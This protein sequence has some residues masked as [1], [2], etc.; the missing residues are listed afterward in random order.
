MNLKSKRQFLVLCAGLLSLSLLSSCG[1]SKKAATPTEIPE[2]AK[3]GVFVLNEGSF[4]GDNASLSFIDQATDVVHNSIY[5]SENP[6][7][8]LGTG[9]NAFTLYGSK[10]YV[11]VFGS[12]K[13]EILSA[14]NTRS[15]KTLTIKEPSHVVSHGKHV[16]VTSY[17]NVV[18]VVDTALMEVV[19]EVQVGRTPEFMA[20]SNGKVFVA[21]AGWKDYLSGGKHDNRLTV[22]NAET[23]EVEAEIEIQDNLS[24]VCADK[25]GRI[26]V[27][28]APIYEQWP[29]L[30]TP[31][32]LYVIDGNNY[33]L[34]REFTFG[35]AAMAIHG[36]SGYVLTDHNGESA[37]ELVKINL[38]NWEVE[39]LEGAL[40]G[41]ESPYTL[42]V[43]PLTGQVWVSDALNFSSNGKVI[44]LS[45]SFKPEKSY[46]VGVSPRMFV[47]KR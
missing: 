1:K 3:E 15:L 18:H 34:I 14:A 31:S 46:S 42:G 36:N 26:Y 23:L 25:N 47:F 28:N 5:E 30:I 40:T 44:K 4:D 22:I 10:L 8:K 19:K 33:A 13:L 32:H 29:T 43:D 27:L 7:K 35:G 38:T 16:F 9:G 2:L 6:N 37:I 17:S 21:N 12:N 39:V 11:A 45:S 20:V 24:Q 41:V